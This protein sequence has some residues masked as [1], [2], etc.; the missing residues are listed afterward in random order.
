MATC[1]DVIRS[2]YR[3]AGII[4][5]S[6]TLNATQAAVGMERLQ[7]MYQGW[8]SNAMFGRFCDYFLQTGDYTA[9]EY[10]RI[11]KN[12]PT[13]VVTIPL[14]LRDKDTG[15]TRAPI[16]NSIISVIDPV[17]HDPLVYI[18]NAFA[19]RWDNVQDLLLTSVAPLS[20]AYEDA[21]KDILAVSLSDELG[22]PITPDL[23]LRAKLGLLKIASKYSKPRQAAVG[24]YM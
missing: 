17:G 3:R 13:S 7:G 12:D 11:Y 14:T 5:A 10:D 22:M 23:G 9:N 1:Q 2:A 15:L 19:A 20:I 18:Y 21:L 6:V 24:E 8:V 16:D 4:A